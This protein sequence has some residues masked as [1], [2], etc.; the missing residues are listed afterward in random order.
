VALGSDFGVYHRVRYPDNTWSQFGDLG[1]PRFNTVVDVAIA[2]DPWDV[3][4]AIVADHPHINVIDTKVFH[5]V[6]HFEGDWT[7]WGWVGQ[8]PGQL[9]QIGATGLSNGE[10]QLTVAEQYGAVH[11]ILRRSDGTWTQWGHLAQRSFGGD[12]EMAASTP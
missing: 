6:R 8:P 11:H 2:A 10:V 5:R 12:V 1:L 9:I 4:V 3:H 7:P